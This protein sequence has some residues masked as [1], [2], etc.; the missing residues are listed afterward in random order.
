MLRHDPGPALLCVL[1]I[2]KMHHDHFYFMPFV[3]YSTSLFKNK[4]GTNQHETNNTQANT[5][6]SLLSEEVSYQITVF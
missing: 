4:R 5:G 3:L 2:P 1:K 6:S